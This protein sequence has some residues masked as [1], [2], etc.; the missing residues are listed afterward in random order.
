[1][2]ALAGIIIGLGTPLLDAWQ[3]EQG[4]DAPRGGT[5]PSW[6]FVLTAIALFV[7]QYAASG[8]LEQ[9]LLD[10]TL[11]GGL[12]ALDC[13][14]AAT[15]I[16]LWAAFDGTRQGLFMACL[17][18]VCGPAV[19]ITLINVFHLYTY[20]HPQWLGV[21]LWIP[22]VYFAGSLAVG[23]LARRV[24]STLQSRRR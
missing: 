18:A 3:A 9:P 19:E 12:P 15:A 17:T 21:P 6:P 7:L 8:A 1:M 22:W 11:L 24:S 10:V 14:L 16:A 4:G 2:F 20:T 5:N 23:N 13:L